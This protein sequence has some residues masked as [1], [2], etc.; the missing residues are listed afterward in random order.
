MTVKLDIDESLKFNGKIYNE[1]IFH[2]NSEIISNIVEVIYYDILKNLSSTENKIKIN[3]ELK[4]RCF[5]Y[6][7]TRGNEYLKNSKYEEAVVCFKEAIYHIGNDLT[8]L[9]NLGLALIKLEKFKESQE[10]LIKALKISPE[11]PQV[12]NNYS[13]TLKEEGKLNESKEILKKI[14]NKYPDYISAKN[15]L[16][17]IYIDQ[18]EF[19]KA[20]KL[21]SE[22]YKVNKKNFESY[23][24][25]SKIYNLTNRYEKAIEISEEALSKFPTMSFPYNSLGISYYKMGDFNKSL[26]FLKK[27]ININELDYHYHNNLG[28]TYLKLGKINFSL[29]AFFK[30]L[31]IRFPF[32]EASS[33]FLSLVVQLEEFTNIKY[34]RVLLDIE[35]RAI[36]S[37]NSLD[38][39][40]LAIAAYINKRFKES[41]TLLD[42]LNNIKIKDEDINSK[43]V[44]AYREFLNNIYLKDKFTKSEAKSPSL[45]NQN[46]MYHIGDSHCL[47]FSHK[48]IVYKNENYVILPKIIFGAKA[49]HFSQKNENQYKA[50]LKNYFEKFPCK[51]KVLISFGEIDCRH[52]EGV[53]AHYL[54]NNILLDE[55]IVKTIDGYLEFILGESEKK[56]LKLIFMGV[57]APVFNKN[58][59]KKIRELQLDI[60]Q[61]WN[62]ILKGKL[63][64]TNHRFIET[65]EITSNQDRYSNNEYMID[66][67]HLSSSILSHLIT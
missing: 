55:I 61:K 43:F 31:M 2:K 52:N 50:M 10:I 4:Y 9:N 49:F 37:K 60:I 35:L 24:N 22:I 17:L 20:L 44:L 3:N 11:L 46:I 36:T 67:T 16:G 30:S 32:E 15:N 1:F 26:K 64:S 56:N 51:S 58:I 12:I 39:I 27:A 6:F 13:L 21:F 25:I 59:D 28:N 65:Y 54:K 7:K 38:L 62:K 8:C 57:H 33:S 19:S 42:I 53:C 47:A 23:Q 14:I 63:A 41:K 45:I 40:Y 18:K 48:S 29:K 34:I 66:N 5:E